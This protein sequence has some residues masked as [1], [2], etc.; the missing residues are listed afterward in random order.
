ML[1][2][3]NRGKKK[4]QT[5]FFSR[6][7]TL[8]EESLTCDLVF[9]SAAYPITPSKASVLKQWFAFLKAWRASEDPE[10]FPDNICHPF[11]PI[12][13]TESGNCWTDL[14]HKYL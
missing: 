10:G 3:K 8:G 5:T 2:K 12:P 1:K 14:Q 11:N 6:F 4:K 13:N 7:S 9:K